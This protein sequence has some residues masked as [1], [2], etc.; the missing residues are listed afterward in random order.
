MVDTEQI[1]QE[2]PQKVLD[3]NRADA[4]YKGFPSFIDWSRRSVDSNRWDRYAALLESRENTSKDIL[5][6]AR[7][8]VKRA[9][10]LDTGAIEGLY[11][12]DRGFTFTVATEAALWE[13]ALDHKG[14]EVKA[15]FESQLHAY[16]YVL[17]LATQAVPIGEA[18]IRTLHAEIC[19]SQ[20]TYKAFTEVGLQELPLPKGVYKHLPNHVRGRDGKIHSYAPVD[21]TP[22]EMHRFCEELRTEAFLAA[23]PV[24]QS[25]YAHYAF[26]CIH[27]FADGN[28]RVARALASVFT[29]RAHSIPLLVLAENRGD[30]ITSLE[31]ADTGNFQL[32]IDFVME[33]ALDGIRLVDES[34][35]AALTPNVDDSVAEIKRLYV[36][37]GGYSHTDVDQAGFKLMELFQAEMNRQIEKVTIQG[38]IG[39]NTQ[40]SGGNHQ[41]TRVS[42]RFPLSGGR[43]I[44]S[45]LSTSQP[46]SAGVVRSFGLEVPKDC[47]RD[48]DLV[49]VNTQNGDAFEARMS[50]LVPVPTAAF[51]MRL[52]V[53][54]ERIIADAA[55]ELS[56]KA[57]EAFKVQGY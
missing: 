23:H 15:F 57:V 2:E 14:A 29:Y 21:L 13:A 42:N 10:A 37:R 16:D 50:E 51:Q 49:I 12:V 9:A 4:G 38:M 30:Y 27:P 28:G 56:R 24:I 46:A 48:D 47:G 26:V 31:S 22:A 33:R 53:F 7:E 43:I 36:T 1:A 17:D 6:K 44:S 41:L 18:W 5:R 40:T 54:A 52:C 8:V 55:G 25:S 20:D 34:I 32:F 19:R 35:R 11:E 39:A 3:P 45:F